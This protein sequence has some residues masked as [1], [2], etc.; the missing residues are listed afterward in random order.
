[1]FGSTFFV[2]LLAIISTVNSEC[3]NGCSGHGTCNAYDIC[4]CDAQHQGNDCSERTCAFGKAHSDIS[5]GDINGDGVVSNSDVIV[6]HNGIVFRYGTTE[7]FPSMTD[8]DQNIL[9]NTAHDYAECSSK[10]TCDRSTG[11]CHCFPGYDGVACQRASCPGYPASCSGHGV[12]KTIKQL[13]KAD[14]G[15]IYELWD[16]DATMGCECDSG[17]F[18][19]DCSLRKCKVGQDPLYEDDVGQRKTAQYFIGIFTTNTTIHD[20]ESL[21]HDGTTDE[22]SGTYR[23]LFTDEYGKKWETA[24][25]YENAD[26]TSVVNA[27]QGIP[28]DVLPPNA[29]R[30]THLNIKNEAVSDIGLNATQESLKDAYSEELISANMMNFWMQNYGSDHFALNVSRS[31]TYTHVSGDVYVLRFPTIS[32]LPPIEIETYID[33]NSNDPT[34]VS[35]GIDMTNQDARIVIYSDGQLAETNDWF[36][37]YCVGVRVQI[38]VD[39]ELGNYLDFVGGEAEGNKLKTCL[40]DGDGYSGN[41][42]G[43]QNWDF[44][45]YLFPHLIKITKLSKNADDDS[46]YLAIY[47]SEKNKKFLM[48]NPYVPRDMNSTMML[49]P[50]QTADNLRDYPGQSNNWYNVFTTQGTMKLVSRHSQVIASPGF[51]MIYTV[52]ATNDYSWIT[53]EYDSFESNTGDLS[54][55]NF[56]SSQHLTPDMASQDS[57]TLGTTFTSCIQKD[58]WILLLGALNGTLNGTSPPKNVD[59]DVDQDPYNDVYG[60]N[61][62]YIN[63]YQV[64][65]IGIRDALHTKEEMLNIGANGASLQGRRYYGM[66]ESSAFLRNQITLDQSPNFHSSNNIEVNGPTGRREIN[67]YKFFP[68]TASTYE[69]MAECSG[70]GTCDTTTGLCQCFAGYTGDACSIQAVTSC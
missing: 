14:Y 45:N 51:S 59:Y 67:V 50:S 29:I 2:F 10:G 19:A 4:T 12:C 20:S 49:S 7:G 68:S 52:N 31:Q 57:M 23:Y 3:P 8:S 36:G 38:K 56:A 6:G 69:V 13:A 18:G 16:E 15:N 61:P 47:Y 54:C 60:N 28:S 32:R 26:C 62:T 22:L 64:K 63:I 11:T 1:M 65:E 55:E 30:C 40:G 35:D 9:H 33:G 21:F 66:N 5:K 42:V 53:P 41:N 27:F 44:G 34:L 48:L 24:T 58:D 43:L 17:Y 37:D 46:D 70:R 39:T 25:L